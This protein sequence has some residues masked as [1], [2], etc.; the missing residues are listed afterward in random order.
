MNLN[1]KIP[2]W[3]KL[4]IKYEYHWMNFHCPLQK[5]VAPVTWLMTHN[6]EQVD[7]RVAKYTAEMEA[8]YKEQRET[9][10]QIRELQERI[11]KERDSNH[12]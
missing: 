6:A 10:R 1:K 9:I 8:F 2:L 7:R 4:R 3:K 5:V 12:F 11:L